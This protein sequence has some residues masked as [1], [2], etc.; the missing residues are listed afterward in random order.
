MDFC[1][2]PPLRVRAFLCL[3]V[4]MVEREEAMVRSSVSSVETA[5]GKEHE[6]RRRVAFTALVLCAIGGLFARASW[7]LRHG[8]LFT[9]MGLLILLAPGTRA[10]RASWWLCALV[11]LAGALL[12]FLPQSSASFPEWRTELIEWSVP[13]GYLH[14]IQAQEAANFW[15]WLFAALVG[16]GWLAKQRIPRVLRP[17]FAW[18]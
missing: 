6:F 12:G 2:Y 3:L 15:L 8:V 14:V 10:L 7:D 5:V 13:V 17:T 16:G 4:S 11:I 1:P 9:G 18:T